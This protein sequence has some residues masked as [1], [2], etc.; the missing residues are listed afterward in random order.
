MK[1]LLLLPIVLL[2]LTACSRKPETFFDFDTVTYYH[3]DITESEFS[4]DKR[5][6]TNSYDFQQLSAI[7]WGYYD[8]PKSIGDR[9]FI[10]GV[11]KHYP[12]KIEFGNS[13]IAPFQEIFKE[14]D[15]VPEFS[16]ACEAFYRDILVFKKSG[17]VTGIAK[18]CFGCQQF[19][20]IGTEDD[21]TGFGE[22][23]DWKKLTALLS[24]ELP[25]G[26]ILKEPWKR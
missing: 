8:Y 17:K 5:S 16:T 20:I 26:S 23:G 22:N 6:N 14:N 7:I 12:V 19:A 2:L 15:K 3:T 9:S 18:L 11:E 4:Y 25:E 13:E 24:N 21:T 10:K 1:K